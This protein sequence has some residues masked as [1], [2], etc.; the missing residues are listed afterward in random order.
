MAFLI[1]NEN[2]V[3]HEAYPPPIFMY[4]E[5]FLFRRTLLPVLQTPLYFWET[6]LGAVGDITGGQVVFRTSLVVENFHLKA[7]NS[8]QN[9]DIYGFIRMQKN[10]FSGTKKY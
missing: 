9:I 5:F 6:L 7:K 3:P 1:L 4:N 2:T 8:P 10:S